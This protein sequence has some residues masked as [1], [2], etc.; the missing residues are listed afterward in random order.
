M[1]SRFSAKISLFIFT[2]IHLAFVTHS[3]S[4]RKEQLLLFRIRAMQ[5]HTAFAI[6]HDENRL[7]LVRFLRSKLPS[8]EDA[9]DLVTVVFTRAW[10]YLSTTHETKVGSFRGLIYH[11]AKNAVADFYRSRKTTVSLDALEDAGKTLPDKKQGSSQIEAIADAGIVRTKL[12][13]LKEEYHDVILFRY[14]QGLEVS[15]I[16]TRMERTENATRVLLH[17]ALKELQK[18]L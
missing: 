10:S 15:E 6:L 13:L 4:E 12:S 5:D 18:Y 3:V 14:F 16:A 11:I 7:G 2:V 9:E 17:R 8:N 1:E